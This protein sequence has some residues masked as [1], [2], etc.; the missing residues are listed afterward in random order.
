M[1]HKLSLALSALG[2]A[3]VATFGVVPAASAEILEE[4]AAIL[5]ESALEANDATLTDADLLG[6]LVQDVTEAEE[7]GLLDPA[8]VDESNALV[9]NP[10]A[11][12]DALDGLIDEQADEQ[13]EN[14]QEEAPA[15]KA[16]FETV[17]AQFQECRADGQTTV[18]DCAQQLRFQYQF[19]LAEVKL[20]RIDEE[21]A[22][23]ADLPEAEQAE[24]L[25]ALEN[26][27]TRVLALLAK[28]EAAAVESGTALT[29]R[30]TQRL[31]G[32]ITEFQGRASA[33]QGTGAANGNAAAADAGSNGAGA[34][35]GAGAGNAAGQG[36]APST[37]P[38]SGN[39]SNGAAASGGNAGG[40][41]GSNGAGSGASSATPGSQGNGGSAASSGRN[42]AATQGQGQ[43]QGQGRNG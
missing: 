5:V 17:R 12:T 8:I 29:A 34:G 26:Q 23:V 13:I 41:A 30:E 33:L 16:A 18:S 27:R 9:E 40:N 25:A 37:N 31:N 42:N 20:A 35:A 21:I 32:L 39:A 1:N 15:I 14:W 7:L 3:A 11:P 4:G 36:N 22:K 6:E 19:A 43:G 24:R 38:G 10:E 2:V 28:A